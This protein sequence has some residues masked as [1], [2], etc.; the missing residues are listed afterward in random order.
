MIKKVACILLLACLSFACQAV[1]ISGKNG[2]TE[3]TVN[4]NSAGQL[5]TSIGSGE[6]QTL[7]RV[8]VVPK[9]T[10]CTLYTADQAAVASGAGVLTGVYVDAVASAASFIIYDS[11]TAAGTKLLQLTALAVAAP[12]VANLGIPFA[13]GLSI[14]VTL[15]AASAVTLCFVQ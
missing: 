14:D 6:N 3:S 7:G 2:T 13:T 9:A 8:M 15:G 1:M 10:A 11:L 4:V 12:Y 5:T